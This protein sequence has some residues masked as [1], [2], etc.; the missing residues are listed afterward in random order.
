MSVNPSHRTTL[1]MTSMT[2]CSQKL[3]IVAEMIAH[4][5]IELDRGS[6]RAGRPCVKAGRGGNLVDPASVLLR[7]RKLKLLNQCSAFR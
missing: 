2:P 4:V 5:R 1:D 6:H 3:R 7:S